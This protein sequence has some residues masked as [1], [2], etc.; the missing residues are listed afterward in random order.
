MGPDVVSVFLKAGIL[1]VEHAKL[2]AA[3]FMSEDWD[4][5]LRKAGLARSLSKLEVVL[6][7]KAFPPSSSG[8]SPPPSLPSSPTTKSVSPLTCIISFI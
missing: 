3:T 7:N 6:L 4:S 5:F 1:D 8:K 2:Q